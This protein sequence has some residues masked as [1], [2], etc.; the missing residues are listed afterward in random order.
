MTAWRGQDGWRTLI[1][2]GGPGGGKST[3][4]A[5]VYEAFAKRFDD[6]ELIHCSSDVESVDAVI[7]P[8][9][10]VAVVDGTPPHAKDTLSNKDYVLYY[11]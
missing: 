8:K 4:L 5:R 6:I 7:M 1:I 3:L 2:K 10:K 11:G 9:I